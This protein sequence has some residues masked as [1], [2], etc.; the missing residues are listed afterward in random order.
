ML[1][2][3]GLRFRL[4]VSYVLISGVAVLLA[5]TLAGGLIVTLASKEIVLEQPGLSSMAQ[6]RAE[7]IAGADA[8]A[9]G[10]MAAA[11]KGDLS[12]RELMNKVAGLWLR[13]ASLSHDLDESPTLRAAAGQDGRLLLASQPPSYSTGSAPP[14]LTNKTPST[15]GMIV[16]PGEPVGWAVRPV[17]VNGATIGLVYVQA[18]AKNPNTP[19]DS[20]AGVSWSLTTSGWVVS[21]ILTFAL[22]VP[23]CVMSGLLSTRRLIFRIQR[24][25]ERV[26][27]MAEGDLKS[28]VPVSGSDEVAGLERGFNAM[29]ERV[30]AAGHA[31]RIVAAEKAQRAERTRIARELHDS[32]SQNL[33]SLGLVVSSMRRSLPEGSRLLEQ[34]E[35]LEQTI[36]HTMREM[37]TMLL[38]LRP[39]AL[40]EMGLVA[41]LRELCEAYE[42]RLGISVRTDLREVALSP[43]AEHVVLRVVQ[44]A[45]GNATR[46]GDA[47]V[48]ELSLTRVD[49]LIELEIHDNGRGFDTK[50][51]NGRH[52]MGLTVM[53][54]RIAELGGTVSVTSAQE[55]GT[56]VRARMPADAGSAK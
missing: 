54:E 12:D 26:A 24:L 11:E 39:V 4:A 47:Q 18:R 22:L 31:E 53:S 48:I 43:D 46:H 8:T 25:A 51:A 36:E 35:T 16:A 55:R 15:S 30:D 1:S 45:L 5:E 34:A 14:G 40:E 3:R 28:R 21:G 13:Q 2:R 10:L 17:L 37:R 56:T 6:Q 33:F 23:L 41:A 44:E 52:G 50:K 42:M 38:Q 32:V 19:P 49:G 7:A 9:M 29:A 27:A 20:R